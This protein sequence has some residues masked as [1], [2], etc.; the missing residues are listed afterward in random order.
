[1]IKY[2][3]IRKDDVMMR[4]DRELLAQLRTLTKRHPLKPTLRA[5]VERAIELMIEDLEEE[6][7]N[8]SK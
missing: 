3:T 1:M 8:V 6:L 7:S 2:T 5:T 4:V